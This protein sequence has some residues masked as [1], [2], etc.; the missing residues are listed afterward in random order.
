MSSTIEGIYSSLFNLLYTYV[1]F[2][3]PK[4]SKGYV[5][6]FTG[7]NI[8][9]F[10]YFFLFYY[11]NYKMFQRLWCYYNDFYTT[12]VLKILIMLMT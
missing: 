2:V 5:I 1:R 6:E 12:N 7:F 3:I 4:T 10:V 9:P 11:Y 8:M